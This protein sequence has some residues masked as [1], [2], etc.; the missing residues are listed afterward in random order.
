VPANILGIAYHLP[1]RIET[2]DQLQQ[3]NPGWEMDRIYEKSGI[4]QRRIAA[5][6]ETA[7]DLGFF[8]AEKLIKRNLVKPDEIDALIL[9]T[10]SPEYYLPSSACILQH[11]LKLGKHV[12]AFDFNLGCSGFVYGLYMAKCFI[13]AGEAR[14]VLLITADTYTRFIHPKDRTVRT[15]FG[16]GAAAALVGP[17]PEAA[18]GPFVLGTDGAGARNL[19]VP[20][21]CLRLPRSP[22]TSAEAADAAGCVRSQDNLFMDGPAIFTF[23]LTVVPRTIKALLDKAGLAAESVDWYAYHQANK[24]MLETLAPRSK[25]PPEKMVLSFE[26]IGNTV[27][28]SIPIAVQRYAEAGKILP[29]Q[30]VM[31]VGFGVGYSWGACMATWR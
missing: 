30:K 21:G 23:A 13:E 20:S 3:E 2:N 6:G 26:D 18:I 27:S 9:C 31:M 24:Y 25:V 28:A 14:N 4:R 11:R 19:I 22:E 29:G 10:Q 5:P 15:L 17:S 7:A 16:D 12:A 8:A 1:D